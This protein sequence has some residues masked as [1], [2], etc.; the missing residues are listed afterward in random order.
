MKYMEC[1][2][3]TTSVRG[4]YNNSAVILWWCINCRLNNYSIH[5]YDNAWHCIQYE[6]RWCMVMNVVVQGVRLAPHTR[7]SDGRPLVMCGYFCLVLRVSVHDRYYC[8]SLMYIKYVH[9]HK[10]NKLFIP[11]SG[12]S[13]ATWPGHIFPHC[14]ACVCVW[15]RVWVCIV[16]MYVVYCYVMYSKKMFFLIH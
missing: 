11:I 1:Q 14:A 10:Y 8:N 16:C 13:E 5:N 9:R 4:L 6:Y 7:P 12:W 15:V 3:L 2:K